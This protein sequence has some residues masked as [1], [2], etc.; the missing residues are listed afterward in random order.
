M[1]FIFELITL[2]KTLNDDIV[3]PNQKSLFKFSIVILGSRSWPHD[4]VVEE[5][6]AS[7]ERRWHEG[8]TR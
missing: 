4:S 3:T 2:F 5:G 7:S 1:L 6:H 8:Q